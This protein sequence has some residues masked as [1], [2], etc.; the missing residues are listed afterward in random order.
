MARRPRLR[1]RLFRRTYGGRVRQL[2]GGCGTG[3]DLLSRRRRR[4]PAS[5]PSAGPLRRPRDQPA[6]RPR[7]QDARAMKIAIIAPLVTAIKEPQRGGSQA[8]VSDLARG[9]AG[10]GN[11]VDVYAA[12]GSDIPG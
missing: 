12:S 8:F 11:D 5:P 3:Q 6:A 9:L 2:P 7:L 10:R 1:V 4:G